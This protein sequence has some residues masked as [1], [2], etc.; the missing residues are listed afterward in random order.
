M[1]WAVTSTSASKNSCTHECTHRRIPRK[2]HWR[3]HT[4]TR[5]YLSKGTGGL[6]GTIPVLK[7]AAVPQTKLHGLLASRPGGRSTPTSASTPTPAC[8]TPSP[9][10]QRG[11]TGAT[12]V[13]GG[14]GPLPLRVRRQSVKVEGGGVFGGRVG[15]REGGGRGHQ[16]L[17]HMGRAAT[18]VPVHLAVVFVV[19]GEDQWGRAGGRKGGEHM[20]EAG[21]SGG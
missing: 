2:T 18:G 13:R 3:T 14:P 20:H 9:G 12:A 7:P 11:A 1:C 21:G 17:H 4:R 16:S 15:M 6:R 19:P 8:T 10:V 5:V